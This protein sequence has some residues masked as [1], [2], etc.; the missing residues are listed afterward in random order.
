MSEIILKN[1]TLAEYLPATDRRS[2]VLLTG[3]RQ[4][5]KTTLS[6]LKYPQLRYI[7]LDAPENRE[8]LR[9]ISTP[10]WSQ[11]VGNAIIDEAQKEPAVFE[12]VKY[13]F[14]E[15]GISFC[16]LLGSS[17]ILLLKKVRE[18]LAGRVAIYELWP[19]MMSKRGDVV[20]QVQKYIYRGN[21]LE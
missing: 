17:Q 21:R 8:V 4:T 10:S 14:D 19:L 2:L 11:A 6:Q 9:N 7:N 13:A 18:S 1:R 20:H 16:L 15:R 12:K 5:G 3:A